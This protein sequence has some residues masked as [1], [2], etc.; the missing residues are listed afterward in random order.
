MKP[1]L[2]ELVSSLV[3]D[4]VA[5]TDLVWTKWDSGL[6]PSFSAKAVSRS[7]HME[8]TYRLFFSEL[9]APAGGLV[10]HLIRECSPMPRTDE[11][12]KG[13]LAKSVRP[14]QA[15]VTTSAATDWDPVSTGTP[16]ETVIQL[17]MASVQEDAAALIVKA[18]GVLHV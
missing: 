2:V 7:G 8:I 12:A 11:E 5:F 3:T 9:C 18:D 1:Q 15:V 14:V 16:L 17:L 13:W 10:V 4:A 6:G